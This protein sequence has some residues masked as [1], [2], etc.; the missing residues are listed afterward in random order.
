MVST[1]NRL[2]KP[3][4]I[5][6]G[7]TAAQAGDEWRCTGGAAAQRLELRRRGTAERCRDEGQMLVNYGW[8]EHIY[9]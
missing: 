7:G 4:D 1:K 5:T 2:D 3:K 9:I 8:N 6:T